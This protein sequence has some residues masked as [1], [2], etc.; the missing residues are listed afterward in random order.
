[1]TS[2]IVNGKRKPSVVTNEDFEIPIDGTIRMKGNIVSFGKSDAII[3]CGFYWGYSE[4]KLDSVAYPVNKANSFLSELT[5]LRGDTTYFWKAFAMNEYG[6]DVGNMVS[7]KAPSIWEAKE[8]FNASVRSR[9]AFFILNN[10]LYI[11]CGERESG[12]GNLLNDTWEYIVSDNKWWQANEFPG[13]QRR[14]PVSFTIGNYAFVGTGQGYDAS[15]W[16]D[17]YRYNAELDSWTEIPKEEALEIRYQAISFSLNNK[18]YLVGGRN[19]TQ[20][21]NDVWQYSLTDEENGQWTRMNDFP[22]AISGGI[23]ISGNNRIFVGFDEIEK[24]LWEYKAETDSWEEF[25][26]LPDEI[27][28]VYSGVLLGNDIYIVDGHN[29]I[30]TLNLTDKSWK[31]KENLPDLFLDKY[32]QGGY[33]NLFLLGKPNSIYVGL[34]FSR[35]FYEYRPLWDN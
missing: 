28:V 6:V 10:R 17:F 20:R 26:K 18:G 1:M 29:D 23:S 34:G 22:I 27:T 13:I 32:G 8:D 15:I 11:T 4:D 21:L 2:G 31:H 30:W 33:Q 12:S 35:Y 3:D 5:H 19:R 16:N 24:T 7:Y 25:A 9:G 14:Y